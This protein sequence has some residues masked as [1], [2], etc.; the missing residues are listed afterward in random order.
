MVRALVA[1]TN[2]LPDCQRGRMG[3]FTTRRR[4]PSQAF[5]RRTELEDDP[6]GSSHPDGPDAAAPLPCL[7]LSPTRTVQGLSAASTQA[8]PEPSVP[9]LHLRY[10]RV[11]L[12]LLARSSC[13]SCRQL[14][15]GDSCHLHSRQS[16]R[17]G[18][19][20]E[21]L[22]RA[23]VWQGQGQRPTPCDT[24]SVVDRRDVRPLPEPLDHPLGLVSKYPIDLLQN[25]RR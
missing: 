12:A 3:R 14:D 10:R 23:K 11:R 7:P 24:V 22:V 19:R 13:W 8:L 21:S 20:H 1:R 4:A 5:S 9:A 17:D 15:A 18:G 16:V 25:I 2:V 6:T